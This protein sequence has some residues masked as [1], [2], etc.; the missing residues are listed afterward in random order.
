MSSYQGIN[1]SIGDTAINDVVQQ[2]IL[3]SLHRSFPKKTVKD[4]VTAGGKMQHGKA[5]N[6]EP[7]K[8]ISKLLYAF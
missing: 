8:V 7:I 5:K 1:H 4:K 3:K 2:R 6:K